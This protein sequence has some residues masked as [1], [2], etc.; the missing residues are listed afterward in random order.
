MKAT[1]LALS[2]QNILILVSNCVAIR[3]SN[4]SLA[5]WTSTFWSDF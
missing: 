1:S 3:S 5:K 4:M 2:D